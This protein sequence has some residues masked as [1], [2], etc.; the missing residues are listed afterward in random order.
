MPNADGWNEYRQLFK[1]FIA[2]TRDDHQRLQVEVAK[3]RTDVAGLR[4][5]AAVQA[6]RS[7]LWGTL[8]GFMGVGIFFLL[9]LLT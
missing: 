8:G 2:E 9:Q 7:G 3:L 6:V 4:T 5:G 1:D